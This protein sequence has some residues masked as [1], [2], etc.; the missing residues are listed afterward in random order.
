[1]TT[2]DWESETANHMY[3]VS[4]IALSLERENHFHHLLE[5][6]LPTCVQHFYVSWVIIF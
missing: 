6:G 4:F 5:Y 1:M 2:L 3:P